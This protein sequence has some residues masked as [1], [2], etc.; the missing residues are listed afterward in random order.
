MI[1]GSSRG[2]AI[3]SNSNAANGGSNTGSSSNAGGGGSAVN[4][5]IC[6]ARNHSD[7]HRFERVDR[8]D[9]VS[10]EISTYKLGANPVSKFYVGS[11]T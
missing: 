1:A 4:N 9:P 5:G 11:G 6:W 7:K 8:L 2:K 3:A 10:R